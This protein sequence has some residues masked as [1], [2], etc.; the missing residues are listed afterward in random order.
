MRETNS[1]LLEVWRAQVGCLL[2]PHRNHTVL[3]ACS[4]CLLQAFLPWS[5]GNFSPFLS[6]GPTSPEPGARGSDTHLEFSLVGASFCVSW[7]LIQGRLSM[8]EQNFCQG[9]SYCVTTKEELPL[10]QQ[11]INYLA[12]RSTSYMKTEIV[13]SN[14]GLIQ[15]ECV[16]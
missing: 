6:H 11:K 7:V 16:S 2:R 14:R 15:C 1:C 12:V 13:E 5:R 9:K 10:Y 4:T 3:P 8:L